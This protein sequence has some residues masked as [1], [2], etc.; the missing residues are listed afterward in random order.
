M[1]TSAKATV[2][3]HTDLEALE[4]KALAATLDNFAVGVIIVADENRILYANQAAVQMFASGRP[5]RS[6]NGRLS[7]RDPAAVDQ[8]GK[9]IGLALDAE[10]EIGTTGI[11][12]V[13]GN[14]F[15]KPA[16]AHVLP[17]TRDDSRAPIMQQ[18]MAAV[19]IVPALARPIVDLTAIA[20]SLRLT[21]SE[22]RLVEKLAEGATLAEAAVR[23]GIADTTAKTHLTHIFS[24][25][26]VS[27]QTELI[28]LI[29]R[30]V[31]PLQKIPAY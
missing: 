9:A 10:S 31:P 17:L 7:S 6:V 2:S 25:T 13:L 4:R 27:R 23:L 28:A 20:D 1:N 18:A 19:F 12:V 5:V 3:D 11:G 16:I 30:L 24:K 29:H 21:R 8:L 22:A 26:G 14:A 15:G